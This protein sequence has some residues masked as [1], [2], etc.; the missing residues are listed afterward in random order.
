MVSRSHDLGAIRELLS[1]AAADVRELRAAAV[2]A[3]KQLGDRQSAQELQ[4]IG[5]NALFALNALARWVEKQ[6]EIYEAMDL[7]GM[8]NAKSDLIQDR[9]EKLQ[10]LLEEKG[11]ATNSK[12]R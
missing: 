12:R 1:E 8:G 7:R 9:I 5:N 10:G 4:E 3:H 11:Y 2:A 6:D